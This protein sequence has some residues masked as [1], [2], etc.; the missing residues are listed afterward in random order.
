MSQLTMNKL[1]GTALGVYSKTNT[2]R[3]YKD[4]PKYMRK[5]LNIMYKSDKEKFLNNF[6]KAD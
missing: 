3:R 4:G 5:M 1:I 6:K 2:N